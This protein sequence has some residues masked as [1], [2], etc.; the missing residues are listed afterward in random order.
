MLRFLIPGQ[1]AA[2]DM[3]YSGPTPDFRAWAFFSPKAQHEVCEDRSESIPR[4]PM[5]GYCVILSLILIWNT[6]AFAGAAGLNPTPGFMFS[7]STTVSETIRLKADTSF[8]GAA[9]FSDGAGGVSVLRSSIDVD[10]SIFRFS[11]GVSHFMWDNVKSVSFATGSAAPWTDLHDVTLQAR[12]FDNV[13]LDDWRYWV[14]GQ[15]SSSFEA[16]FPGAVG[17]GFDGGIAYDLW[18]GWMVGLTGKTIA[19]NPLSQDL[20]GDVEFGLVLAVSQS[21]LHDILLTMGVLDKEK[22]RDDVVGFS[23]ALT[24]SDKTYRLSPDSPVRSNGYVGIVRSTLGAYLD[25]VPDKHWSFSLGPE[26]H[27]A[28][29]YKL[30]DSSGKF[31]SSHSVRD[32]FGGYFRGRYAF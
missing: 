30:Y 19:L 20:F 8:V 32:A 17:A 21:T 16:D 9:G 22:N 2:G 23:L 7:P 24:G 12:L 29:K 13:F 15:I 18:N 1:S 10:Y 26:Y 25:Y 5:R 27:Y 31:H 4:A 6:S 11:Y 14:N 3:K 28:R